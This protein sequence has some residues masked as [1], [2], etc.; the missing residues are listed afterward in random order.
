MIELQLAHR[1]RAQALAA[2]NLKVEVTVYPAIE[3]ARLNCAAFCQ[4]VS[5]PPARQHLL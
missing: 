4:A 5:K 2:S 1:R 3:K